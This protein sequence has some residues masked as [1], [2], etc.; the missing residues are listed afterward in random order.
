MI[1]A[2]LRPMLL[3]A[4]LLTAP[5]VLARD[6]VDD[7]GRRVTVPDRPLRIVSL[8]DADLT[9]PLLELGIIPIASQGRMGR[10]GK[11]FIRSSRTLTGLDFDNTG[12]E[13][14]GMHP[15]DV[16]RLAALKPD[17][18]L[19]LKGRPTPA[20]QL[21]AIAPTVVIDELTRNPDG[22]Y[23][24]L[25]E[26]TNRR[27]A[28]D[29]LKRRYE[30]QIEQLRGMAGESPP[31]ISVIAASSDRKINVERSYGSIGL[32]LRDA[33]FPSP[34]LTRTIAEN[35]DA[36]FSPEVLPEFDAD[37][38]FDTFR[39]DR[40]E[41]WRDAHGR[42]EALLPGYCRFLRACR[43]GRYYFLPRDEAKSTSYAARLMAIAMITGIMS[44]IR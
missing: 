34:R 27:Q 41:T 37:V 30:A 33:G 12:M 25:A 14:L 35:S 19:I 39:N 6:L 31:M 44:S 29:V 18:I 22:V 15:I 13:F 43:D 21:Q 38:I 36:V 2:L 1:S 28:L 4:L 16:E 10:D 24:L 11:P 9:V 17:L 26:L 20:E 32:V 7:A 8:D 40:N 3:A 42:M 23:A 5:A